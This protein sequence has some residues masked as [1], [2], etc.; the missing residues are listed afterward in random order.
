MKTLLLDRT[1]WDLVKD[2]SGN[3]ALAAEP[4]A[5][6][7]DTGS[8]VKLFKGELW[9]DTSK[10]IPYWEQIL[11]RYPPLNIMKAQFQRAALTVPGVVAALAFISSVD[12]RTVSGQV[13]VTDRAGVLQTV[14]F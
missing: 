14:V 4:Y 8:A 5:L 10:G 7:Q 6:A 3:I 12:D 13:Q 11:G 2:A 1:I 9:Y